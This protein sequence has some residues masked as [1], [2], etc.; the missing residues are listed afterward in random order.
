M[1]ADAASAPRWPT[2]G[3]RRLARRER[4]ALQ[5]ADLASP[6]FT[7]SWDRGAPLDWREFIARWQRGGPVDDATRS[8]H[9]AGRGGRRLR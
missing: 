7:E 6:A 4:P 1:I 3:R 2:R 8:T 5:A 9:R